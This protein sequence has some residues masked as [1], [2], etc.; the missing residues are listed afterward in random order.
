M[1]TSCTQLK[2]KVSWRI[3]EWKETAEKWKSVAFNLAALI[4]F[5]ILS[6]VHNIIT[7]QLQ[8][9]F[10][11]Y[12]SSHIPHHRMIHEWKRK[13]VRKSL[14]N[15]KFAYRGA[16]TFSYQPKTICDNVNKRFDSRPRMTND[17]GTLT[18]TALSIIQSDPHFY[19]FSFSSHC[20][21]GFSFSRKDLFSQT[22]CLTTFDS[23]VQLSRRSS[24]LNYW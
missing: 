5:N 21:S 1:E 9:I 7:V 8:E 16:N 13:N 3:K 20:F 14:L 24:C 17:L 19:R 22:F 2:M 6:R 18:D 4:N 23:L 11:A 10:F 15:P 12:N